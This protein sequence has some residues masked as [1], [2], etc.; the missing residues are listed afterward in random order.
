MIDENKRFTRALIHNSILP[1]YFPIKRS[2]GQSLENCKVDAVLA[3]IKFANSKAPAVQNLEF[4]LAGLCYTCHSQGTLRDTMTLISF[5]E[6][7]RRMVL[8]E[9]KLM[10]TNSENPGPREREITQF[11]KLKTDDV[12][13]FA[14]K[15]YSLAKKTFDFLEPNECF[16]YD[17]LLYHLR[18]WNQNNKSQMRW[19][20]KIFSN[21]IYNENIKETNVNG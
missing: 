17:Q 12:N 6:V 18:F 13:Y 5:E 7:L 11:L 2:F 21:D 1:G 9:R 14:K 15:F 8:T 10:N 19:A 3:Y 20:Y 16:D 4:L